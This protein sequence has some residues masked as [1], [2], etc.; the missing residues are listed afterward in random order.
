MAGTGARLT[1]IHGGIG[2]IWGTSCES[3]L[4]FYSSSCA[5]NGNAYFYSCKLGYTHGDVD[6]PMDPILHLNSNW[7]CESS[8]N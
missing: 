6:T 2:F 5:F 3:T 4:P 1:F 7:G 8:A